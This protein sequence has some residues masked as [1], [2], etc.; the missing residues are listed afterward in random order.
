MTGL[1]AKQNPKAKII[2]TSFDLP[3][4]LHHSFKCACVQSGDSIKDVLLDFVAGYVNA[5][6][7]ENRWLYT[8]LAKARVTLHDLKQFEADVKK[9]LF[10]E[11][12]QPIIKPR[13]EQES[14]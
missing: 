8:R 5:S 3:E 11:N 10:D 6:E 2:K 7:G 13:S 14:E 1:L 4:A 12:G 9:G